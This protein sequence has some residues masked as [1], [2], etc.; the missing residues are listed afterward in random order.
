MFKEETDVTVIGG[1]ILGLSTAYHLAKSGYNVILVEMGKIAACASGS[2]AGA[3][4]KLDPTNEIDSCIYA[5]S[6]KM[7]QDWNESGELGCDIELSETSILRCFTDEHVERMKYGLWKRRLELWDKA[8]LHLV[9]RDEWTM[10]EPNVAR[11]ITWGIETSTSMIN[12]FRVCRGLAW[13]AE[14]NGAKILTNTKVK[15]VGV[16]SGKVCKVVTDRGDIKTDFVV[17][18][19]GAWAPIIG[20]MVGI[21]I[22]ILPAIG[23][24]LVTEPT[25]SITRHR[26]IIYDPLWHDRHQPFVV[27][28]TDP[29]QRLGVTTEIDRHIAEDNYILARSEHIVSLPSKGAKTQTEPET[30]KCIA[31]G[32]IRVIPKLKNIHIIRVYA[33]MRPVCEVDGKPIIGEVN[34]IEGFVLATGIWHTGMSYGPMCGKLVSEIIERKV[35]SIPIEELHYSRF[36]KNHHFPYIHQFKWVN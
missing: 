21:E 8:G 2:N 29:C 32:V 35:T 10:M 25:P 13:T 11:D 31:E 9:K 20:R 30:L 1:G 36:V 7:Y 18:A 27:N 28:S 4:R 22:P 17:N 26:R 24:A 33:G 19:A 16:K 3:I 34:G 23:T 12:I 15:G 6:Y 5:G 14:K